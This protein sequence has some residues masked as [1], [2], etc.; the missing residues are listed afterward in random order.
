M[1]SAS[2]RPLRAGIIG[3]GVGRSHIRGYVANGA[4]VVALAGLDEERCRQAQQEYSIPYVYRDYQDLLARDDLDMVSIAV[5]NYLHAEIAL[6]ALARGLH[7]CVEKPLAHTVADAER[8]VNAPRRPDQQLMIMFNWRFRSDSQAMKRYVETGATGRLYY[9]KAGWMR[10]SGI[11]GIGGWF[12]QKALSGGGPLIDLGVHMLDL[13]LWL[14]G[15]PKAVSVAGA[16]YAEFGPRGRGSFGGRFT[17]GAGGYEVEDLATA[18]I[19]LETGTT[20]LLEASW[21]SFSH[22]KDDFYVHLYGA[23]GGAE[24]NVKEYTEVDTLTFYGEVAGTP[25]EMKPTVKAGQAH[26]LGIQEFMDAIREKRPNLS[27]P[28][29]GLALMQII[30]GIYRSAAEGREI[31]L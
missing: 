30:D 20:L 16:T 1:V 3:C 22:F 18:F 15:Y 17:T 13:S 21:A 19:R 4:E 11:P 14:L 24:M 8:I 12:T 25:V 29:Q 2:P 28:E 27:P 31:Q 7:V 6:A 26:S 5:P 23:D 10:R 9:A